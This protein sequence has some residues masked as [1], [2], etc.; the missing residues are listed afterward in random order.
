MPEPFGVIGMVQPTLALRA[1]AAAKAV[2]GIFSENSARAAHGLLAGIYPGAVGMPPTPGTLQHL[3]AYKKMPWLRAVAGRIASKVAAAEWK[4]YVNRRPGEKAKLSPIVLRVQRM[5]DPLERRHAL[6]LLA[7]NGEL[8][9]L[10]DHVLV[11]LLND[12]NSFLTGLTMR[13]VTQLHLDIVGDAFWL[14]ERGPGN[15]IVGLW[16]IPPHW[17]LSTP[18]PS[19]RVFRVQF[20]AWRGAIPDTEWIWFSD[21]D[22]SN[23]YGRGAGTAQA[24]TDELEAD[25]YAAKHMKSF[26]YNRARPDFLVYPKIGTMTE[27]NVARLEDDWMNRNQGFWKAFK[28][29]F[30]SK[31]VGIHE[32]GNGNNFRSQ[33]LVQLRQ[34]ERDVVMQTFGIPPEILGVLENSN[35]ATI[36]AA[37]TVFGR[38][39]LEP[40]LE[41]M[42]CVMQERLVPEFDERII[43]DYTSPVQDDKDFTLDVSKAHPYAFSVD[44][45]RG[46]VNLPEMDKDV[47]KVHFSP[48]NF[49]ALDPASDDGLLPPPP[50][51]NP[52]VAIPPALPPGQQ[53]KPVP[54]QRRFLWRRSA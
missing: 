24:L 12:A 54:G 31:E 8:E 43:L 41:L 23:P 3:E 36:T 1:R 27:P 28:P 32:F 18:T 42:R 35:R 15:T 44:E 51:P 29:Y 47:G 21:V 19:T 46:M 53:P 33:Q 11:D 34:H 26:F 5:H 4:V 45:I 49:E 39:V 9:Q 2:V 16:P 6:K 25:E 50:D 38:Y 7:S 22:P 10:T 37:D 20:R 52:P 14:K 13:K 17:I 30:M 48:I 40:R